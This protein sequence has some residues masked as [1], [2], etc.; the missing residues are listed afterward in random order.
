MM[1]IAK[2][3][4]VARMIHLVTVVAHVIKNTRHLMKLITNPLLPPVQFT[5]C[6]IKKKK[7]D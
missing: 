2:L 1:L 7:R 5:N 6:Y 4:V 3:V